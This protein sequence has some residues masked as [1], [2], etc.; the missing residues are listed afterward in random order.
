VEEFTY[1]GDGSIPKINKSK[2][3]PDPVDDLNPYERVE[4]ETIAWTGGVEVEDCSEG[5]RNV[6]SIE[7]NDYIKVKSVDFGTGAISFEA[8][9]A[10]AGSGG[11]IELH[12]ESQTGSL[13]GTCTVPGT[14]GWQTWDSVNCD[15]NTVAGTHDLF[16][17]F[18]GG[19]GALF[20]LDW[21]QFVP[22]D[23]ILTGSGGSAGAGGSGSGG[24]G[25]MDAA[26]GGST[27]SSGGQGP[28][29]GGSASEAGGTT[30]SGDGSGGAAATGGLPG[31]GGQMGG[32]SL[33][34][35]PSGCSCALG[36]KR[37]PNRGLWIVF[38]AMAVAGARR[39]W[40]RAVPRL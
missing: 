39:Q 29:S 28:G 10:S 37:V 6:A 4:G 36:P 5:G 8:T 13:L 20:N 12:L 3:G 32:D 26:T 33:D 22:K 30:G 7:N 2:T 35:D 21:W 38:A 19:N 23:P 34:S 14:G 24:G 27:A 15:V 25:G 1:G 9:V 11:S 31:A 18:K 40:R 17:V 16:L